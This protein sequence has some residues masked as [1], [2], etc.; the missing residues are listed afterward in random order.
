MTSEINK[1]IIHAYASEVIEY[2]YTLS[3]E[4]EKREMVFSFYGN[5][6]FLLKEV[7]SSDKNSNK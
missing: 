1:H 2:I 3:T 4:Q 7:E 6:F 5:Y